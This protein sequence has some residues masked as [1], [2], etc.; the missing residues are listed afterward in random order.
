LKRK[1][2]QWRQSV[3]ARVPFPNM[4]YD[5]KRAGEWWRL[6][7]NKVIKSDLRKRYPQTEASR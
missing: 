7:T 1:L 4:G 6:R 3:L 5:V 2:G